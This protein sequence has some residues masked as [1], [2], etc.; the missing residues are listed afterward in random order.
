MST[1][2]QL[3]ASERGRRNY[4]AAS[5]KKKPSA[6]EVAVKNNESA[7]AYIQALVD[8]LAA[9]GK[10]KVVKGAV[11][12]HAQNEL[13]FQQ[14]KSAL[15]DVF[16]QKL[17]NPKSAVK[18]PKGKVDRI[19]NLVISDTHY[20]SNLDVREVGKSYGSVEEA[21]RTAAI[22]RQV[23]N[24][25]TQYRDTTQL[26]VHI[27]GDVIQGQLHDPRDGAPLVEQVG[28]CLRILVQ[29]MRFLAEQFPRGVKVF[30]VP[31]NHGRN[32]ARHHVRAVNQKF[33]AIETMVYL[34]LKEAAAFIPN[35]EVNLGY[36]PKY[37][38]D[39]FGVLGMAT[40]GDT[41]IN[42]GYPGKSIDVGGMK[43]QIDSIN[44][45]R[46]HHGAK[47][48][49]VVVVGHVHVGSITNLPGGV[50]VITNGCLIPPDAY[51]NSI[52]IFDTA[53]GQWIWESVAGHPVG[54][55]RFMVVGPSDDK[56]ATLDTII[57][58]YTGF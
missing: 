17:A 37:D 22:C 48:Y 33:D 26:M 30:C 55:A 57:K 24:Y 58:P 19:V 14:L 46:T 21:R 4:E 44:N 28:A 31:G 25:K 11:T 7:Y 1:P 40:H 41:V 8:G 53:C 12:T 56:D 9:S 49:S 6:R 16:S 43:R 52:G 34:G 50:T 15:H 13:F 51:A 47:P 29:A 23:A 32:S 38:F 42:P 54:D 27:L 18:K 3:S 39:L 10:N 36:E 2:K 20:G 45:A 5:P 35:L